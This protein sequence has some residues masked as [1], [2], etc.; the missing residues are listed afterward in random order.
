MAKYEFLFVNTRNRSWSTDTECIDILDFFLLERRVAA[1]CSL[2]EQVICSLPA[3]S[4]L[5]SDNATYLPDLRR[6]RGFRASL[7]IKA[8]HKI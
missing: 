5:V 3:T 4:N 2:E 8:E 7:V 1:A 6:E